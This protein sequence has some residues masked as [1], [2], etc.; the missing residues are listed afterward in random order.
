MLCRVVARVEYPFPTVAFHKKELLQK[1]CRVML[2]KRG[3]VVQAGDV[4]LAFHGHDDTR[5]MKVTPGVELHCKSGKFKHDDIIGMQYGT[6][7]RGVSNVKTD[8]T[9]PTLLIL[10]CSADL[11][12]QAVPHRTQIIYSTDIAVILMNLRVKPGVFVAEAG[13]GSGSLTHSFARAVAPHGKVFTFDFHR[14]RALQAKDEFRENGVGDLVVSGWRDVCT[15]NTDG[16]DVNAVAWD[17]PSTPHDAQP[18]AGLGLPQHHVDALFLDV[19][20]PWAAID[21]VLHVLKPGGMLCTFSPCIEQTQRTCDRLRQ[22]PSEFIDIRTVEALTKYFDPVFKRTRLEE[23]AEVSEGHAQDDASRKRP[24]YR[25]SVMFRPQ[26]ASKGH[27][28]YLT[29][30]RRRLPR[31]AQAVNEDEVAVPK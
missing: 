23:V 18:L 12:T 24:R 16:D 6:R 28:A 1:D 10:Q 17:D 7:V 3:G 31:T 2:A 8:T 29:F 9:V 5:P 25:E 27:S 20:A 21:N 30:A 22:E 13:T 19:P 11:W 26:M 14:G 15:T 4:V